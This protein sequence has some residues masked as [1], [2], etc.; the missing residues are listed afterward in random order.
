MPNLLILVGTLL[1]AV[2]GIVATYGWNAK[3]EAAQKAGMI[4]AVAAEL[5]MNLSI[6]NDQAIV[7]PDDKKLSAFVMFPRMLTT[8]LEGAISSG[9]F[10]QEKDRLFL[11]RAANLH[12]LLLGFNQRLRFTEEQMATNQEMGT[13]LRTKL[14]DGVVRQQV[15]TKLKKFAELLISDYGIK[16]TDKFFVVLEEKAK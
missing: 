11:T 7:E 16:E 13:Q 8:A 14:R 15:S 1:I 12:E 3:T 4:R 5:T 9:L 6:I 10:L 2:G